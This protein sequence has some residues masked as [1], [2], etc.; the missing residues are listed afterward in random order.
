LTRAQARALAEL[1]PDVLVTPGDE[2]LDWSAEFGRSAP[3]GLE[4]GFG[5]GAAL[6]EWAGRCAD[7]NLVG[8]DIYQ[9]GIGALLLGVERLQLGNVRVVAEDVRIA[10]EACFRP[11]SLDEVHIFFPDPWPKKRHHK[12]RLIQAEFVAELAGRMRSGAK[13]MIATDWQNYAESMLV[14]LDREPR[15][16]NVAGPGNF[17]D[18]PQTRS[19]TRFEARGR[20]LGHAVWDL[21]YVRNR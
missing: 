12:R 17:C 18:R 3:L 10:L 19:P 21:A 13:L 14:V 16:S 1:G 8:V 15:F 7:W 2:G 9:P 11:A 20:K 4:I 6:L 5:T